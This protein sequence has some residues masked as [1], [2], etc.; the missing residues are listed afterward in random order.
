MGKKILAAIDNSEN[1]M[2]AV[3]FIANSLNKDSEVTLFSIMADIS[4]ICGLH[5]PSL[6]PAFVSG[7]DYFC[8]LEHEK[9]EQLKEAANKA[10]ELLVDAGFGKD[11]ITKKVQAKKKGTARDIISESESGYDT[12]VLGRRGLSGIKEFV[13]GSVSQKVL[14]SIKGMTIILVD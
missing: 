4:A 10:K 11:K 3:E 5:D 6:S 12:I 9:R 2:R 13:L 1:A 14:H 8:A 7:K